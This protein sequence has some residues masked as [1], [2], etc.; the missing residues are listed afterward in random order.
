MDPKATYGK[1]LRKA[2][3]EDFVK[4]WSA[5]RSWVT[6]VTLLVA[7]SAVAIQVLYRGVGSMANVEQTLVTGLVGL[8]VSMAGN[9]IISTWRGAKNLDANLH[10]EIKHRDGTISE[11]ENDIQ[12][13]ERSIQAILQKPKRTAAEEHH[14][15]L[16]IV[17]LRELGPNGE[18]ILRH[19]AIHGTLIFGNYNPQLPQGFNGGQTREILEMCVAKQLVT[20]RSERHPAGYDYIYEISAGMKTALDE[21]LYQA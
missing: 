9:C 10:D 13:K 20:V 19:L 3:R 7:S 1:R 2:A 16:A 6:L 11:R 8:V 21:L 12:E 5:H 18:A 15:A 17:A 4:F 14:Y